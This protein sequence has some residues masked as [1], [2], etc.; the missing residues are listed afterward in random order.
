MSEGS[1]TGSSS[2]PEPPEP[3]DLEESGGLDSTAGDLEEAVREAVGGQGEGEDAVD[4]PA[5]ARQFAQY[6]VVDSKQD[7]RQSVTPLALLY[8]VTHNTYEDRRG[9]LRLEKK[10][11]PCSLLHLCVPGLFTY[12]ISSSIMQRNSSVCYCVQQIDT[13]TETASGRSY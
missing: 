4:L 11:L 6:L 10:T 5:V 1:S 8:I 13:L 7:V 3:M 2:S 9:K 12:S